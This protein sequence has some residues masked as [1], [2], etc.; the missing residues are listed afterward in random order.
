MAP[1]SWPSGTSSSRMTDMTSTGMT[2]PARRMW[3]LFEPVHAVTYFAPEA[4]DAFKAAGLRGFWRGYFAGRAAPL[5][6]TGA[7]VVTASFY[8]FAPSFV[9][10]AVPGV[11]EL[12]APDDAMR[13][14]REGAVASLRELLAGR[15]AEVK[16][17]ANL[18]ERALDGLD[19]A[20]RV[21][22]AA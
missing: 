20:G 9:A 15:D 13:V 17:A 16:A 8:N 18:L 7:A 6:M 2:G 12:I 3:T 19:D 5:G 21:L 4:L 22:A 1:T 14:R 11:W 10:R